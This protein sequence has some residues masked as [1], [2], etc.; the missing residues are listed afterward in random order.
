MM[1]LKPDAQYKPPAEVGWYWIMI[2]EYPD[3]LMAYRDMMGDWSL[4]IYGACQVSALPV[5]KYT[6]IGW[7]KIKTLSQK[8]VCA[9]HTEY[10]QL[11]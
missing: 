8:Q 4:F 11:K 1:K 6:L 10:Q 2:G 5:G 3:I 9:I 7:A